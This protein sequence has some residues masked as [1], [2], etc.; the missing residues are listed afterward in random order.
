MLSKKTS[1]FRE[2]IRRFSFLVCAILGGLALLGNLAAF[3]A[4]RLVSEGWNIPAEA[5]S[6]GI[7]GGAD[8]PTAVFVTYGA[9]S[10]LHAVLQ[11]LVPLILLVLGVWG[12]RRLS[13]QKPDAA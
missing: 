4:C 9:P 3:I 2:K 11:W 12:F 6:I 8:G 10:G 1:G 13:R 7:I 5:A